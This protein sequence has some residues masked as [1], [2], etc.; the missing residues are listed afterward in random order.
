VKVNSC[1]SLAKGIYAYKYTLTAITMR[2]RTSILIERDILDK[3][4]KSGVNVSRTCENAL[5]ICTEKMQSAQQETTPIL[6]NAGSSSEE[7]AWCGRRDLN[8]GRQRGRL[9]S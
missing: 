7:S 8:P 6:L 3:A 2:V 1:V 9:M 4:L 5:I